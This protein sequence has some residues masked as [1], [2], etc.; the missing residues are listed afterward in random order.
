MFAPLVCWLFILHDL[1]AKSPI[2]G[3]VGRR[4]WLARIRRQLERWWQRQQVLVGTNDSRDSQGGGIGS[5]LNK[6]GN[7]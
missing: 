2:N 6:D 7:T 3:F 4:E 1:V 5:A